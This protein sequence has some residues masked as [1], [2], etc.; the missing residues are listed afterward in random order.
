MTM[1]AKWRMYLAELLGTFLLI[2][3]G[4]GS[5]ISHSTF[6][7]M[8]LLGI[9][10]AHGLAIMIGIYA[11][12]HISGA[13]F[14]PAVTSAMMV[15]KRMT[16]VDGV[17][18]IVSQLLG[19]TLAALA[20]KLSF[21]DL[22]VSDFGTPSLAG[23]L[24]PISGIFIEAMMTF[25]LVMVIFAVAVHQE[26]TRSEVAGLAIGSTIA[27]NILIGGVL[28]GGAMNPARWFGPALASNIW[29]NWYVY[30]AGPLVGALLAALLYQLFF[31]GKK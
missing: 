21:S 7:S 31:L 14:N 24:S 5:V 1:P 16:L 28:T 18:Y 26:K 23:G 22:L 17:S 3:M 2:Y 10:I 15:T 13:H 6:G 12:G 9:A 11:F 20:L 8:D 30:L 19:G 27:A 29:T 25:I 4:A